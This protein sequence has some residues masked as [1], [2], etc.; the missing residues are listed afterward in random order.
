MQHKCKT[1]E[2]EKRSIMEAELMGVNKYRAQ[3]LKNSIKNPFNSQSAS[4]NN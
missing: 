4:H 1:G 2:M 3:Q